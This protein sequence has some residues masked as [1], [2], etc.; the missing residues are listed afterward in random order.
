MTAPRQ[1]L[2]PEARAAAL[3]VL[4]RPLWVSPMELA[5]AR[6]ALARGA[7]TPKQARLLAAVA[8]RL[9]RAEAEHHPRP[10]Q[11]MNR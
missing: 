10:T 7:A 5:V 2:A 11:G 8:A 1:P 9:A 6:D 3:H 4:R